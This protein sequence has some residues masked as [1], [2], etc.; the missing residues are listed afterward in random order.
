[1]ISLIPE[2]TIDMLKL[3]DNFTNHKCD[4]SGN[5]TRKPCD[6]IGRPNLPK[7]S[8]QSLQCIDTRIKEIR[9]YPVIMTMH[10]FSNVE[11]DTEQMEKPITVY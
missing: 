9:T 2:V 5:N 10:C 8:G 1:M 6:K 3:K 11:C 4:P 7:N